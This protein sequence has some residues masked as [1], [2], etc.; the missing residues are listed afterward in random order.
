MK[1][2]MKGLHR[3]TRLAAAAACLATGAL[4]LAACGSSGSGSGQQASAKLTPV[5]VI[6]TPPA[7][8]EGIIYYGLQEGIFAKHGIDLSVSAPSGA[9]STTVIT[10]VAQGKF[11][12]GLGSAY[13]LPIYAEKYNYNVKDFFGWGQSNPACVIVKK[14]SGITTPQQLAGKSLAYNAGSSSDKQLATFQKFYGMKAGSITLEATQST[15]VN[16]DFIAGAVD[17][18]EAYAYATVPVFTSK[19]IPTNQFCMTDAG[20]KY[21]ATGFVATTS[22]INSHKATLQK[23]T[24]ALTE[25]FTDAAKNPMAVGASVTT[26]FGAVSGTAQVNGLEVQAELPFLKTSNTAGH[27]YG[28][29]APADWQ[30]TLQYDETYDGLKTGLNPGNYYTDEFFTS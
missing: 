9:Q 1:R 26:K 18:I 6:L 10:D 2:G 8:W 15:A 28:W 16:G 13:N 19:G 14:S 5:S 11:D 25:A 17:A 7:G 12:V 22:Y 21:E 30:Q 24:A 27:P 23:L 29:M 20:V 3:Q 4:L